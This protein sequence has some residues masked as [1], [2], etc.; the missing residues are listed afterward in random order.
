LTDTAAYLDQASFTQTLDD[1]ESYYLPSLNLK[2]NLNEDMLLRFG[3][4]EALTFPNISDM[5]ASQSIGMNP[6][7]ISPPPV[8]G[9]PEPDGGVRGFEDVLPN[10]LFVNGGN[11][12]LRPT[13]STNIDVSYEWYFSGGSYFSLG[14]FHKKLDDIIVNS[15]QEGIGSVN[16]DGQDISI[17]YSGT[18]NQGSGEIQ[19][20]EIAGQYFF[21][22]APGILA[23]TGIQANFTYI[24]AEVDPVSQ[25]Q[26][27]DLDGEP[28]IGSFELNYRQSLN[29]LLG[30][31][32]KVG[33][34]VLIYQDDKF[35]GRLAYQYRSSYLNSYRDYITGNPI[36]QS[37]TG[38]LD[39][40][41]R[42][43]VNDHLEFSLFVANVLDEK[44]QS[45]QI[46]DDANQRQGRSSFIV[47]RRLQIGAQYSF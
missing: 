46:I 18:V 7:L 33:N 17:I 3:I 14:L 9:E 34:L 23:H 25:F 37:A 4:S 27:T 30:N 22:N 41:F 40:S 32:D 26:D 6:T 31:S 42:Y 24:D 20:A 47:D 28:D 38:F 8:E 11:P 35:E 13:I 16:L 15:G 19:G 1:S 10:T 44:S 45:Q 2:L 36:E 29:G 43:S 21:D 39:A 12:N 5:S